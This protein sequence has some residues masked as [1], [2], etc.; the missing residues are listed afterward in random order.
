MKTA[1]HDISGYYLR[2]LTTSPLLTPGQEVELAARIKKG[3]RKSRD[4]MICANLRLVVK[5][6]TQF[7]GRGLPLEDL[8]SE[9]NV[10]L[11]KAVERF[12][13]GHGA[14]FSTYAAWWIKQAMHRAISN[15]T[16]VIRI[17]EHL[18][19]KAARIARVSSRLSSELGREATH[20]EVAEEVGL[21]AEKV[22]KLGRATVTAVSLDAPAR[23]SE[24]QGKGLGETVEDT[25]ARSPF[26][27]LRDKNLRQ[28]VLRLLVILSERERRVIGL[29]FGL[30]DGVERTLEQVSHEFGCTRE[31]I[32]LIQSAALRK[33][34]LEMEALE[35]PRGAA[36]VAA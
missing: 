1:E 36:A 15:Q 5:I 18:S 22:S 8:V 35:K 12:E 32:R 30:H 33:L 9:G 16:G 34:R 24:E 31:N 26:D 3:C 14:K 6:A 25:H 27:E 7:A 17:P 21:S 4:K 13:P 2:R 23:G 11:M 29:R 19:D 10:G 20:Q 28:H